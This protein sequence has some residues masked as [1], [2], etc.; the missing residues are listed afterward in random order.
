MWATSMPSPK[1]PVS[2]LQNSS[3]M[4]VEPPKGIKAN[5]LKTYTGFNDDFFAACGRVSIFFSNNFLLIS[6]MKSVKGKIVVK[7]T[8]LRTNFLYLRCIGISREIDSLF[9]FS[10][11]YF[12][13]YNTFE[14]WVSGIYNLF[15]R[16]L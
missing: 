3:K 9:F 12:N 16:V 7:F 4:T 8:N 5:L 6:K 10:K 13:L 14:I 2:I 15:N 11:S 1:F